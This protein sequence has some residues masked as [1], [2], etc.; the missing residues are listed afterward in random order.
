MLY[1][2]TLITNV[3]KNFP[4]ISCHCYADDTQLYVSFRPDAQEQSISNLEACVDYIRGWMLQ[5]QAHAKW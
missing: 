2:A 3:Q 1:T 5:K 4:E